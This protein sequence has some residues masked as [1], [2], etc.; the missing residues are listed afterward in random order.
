MTC[1]TVL[2]SAGLSTSLKQLFYLFSCVHGN[3]VCMTVCVYIPL[4]VPSQADWRHDQSSLPPG[5]PTAGNIDIRGFG[6]RYREDQEL[7]VRNI[8]VAIH[9]GEKVCDGGGTDCVT[10]GIRPR[11]GGLGGGTAD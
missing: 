4:F 1:H 10:G 6:L 7:A 5:W 2:Q 11:H 9:G 8:T 3:S